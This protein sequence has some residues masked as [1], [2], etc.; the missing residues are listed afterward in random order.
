MKV[1]GSPVPWVFLFISPFLFCALGLPQAAR[2]SLDSWHWLRPQPTSFSLLDVAEGPELLVAVGG[3]GTIQ[4][5]SDGISWI[6]R[7]S[8]VT[9]TLRGIAY[10]QNQFVAAGNGSVL[11]SSNGLSW[12]CRPT[13]T[14]KQLGGIAYGNGMF[15]AFTVDSPYEILR[16]FDA[17]TWIFSPYTNVFSSLNQVRFCNGLFIGTSS[18]GIVTSTNGVDWQEANISPSYTYLTFDAIYAGGAWYAIGD[19]YALRST[20]GQNWSATWLGFVSGYALAYG[21]GTL[22]GVGPEGAVC[23]SNNGTNWTTT[24]TGPA[25]LLGLAF[26]KN[27]FVAVGSSG[28]VLTS[29]NGISWNVVEGN[30][31]NLHRIAKVGERYYAVG[32]SGAII[33]SADSLHWTNLAAVTTSP[34]HDVVGNDG[35]ML[36]VGENGTVVTSTN[37][38]N[39]RRGRVSNGSAYLNSVAFGNGQFV[40]TDGFTMYVSTNGTNWAV[41]SVG[42]LSGITKVAF[43]GGFFVAV[44]GDGRVLTSTDGATWTQR[45][46]GTS[47]D[48]YD[49]I[50]ANGSYL[51]VGDVLAVSPDGIHWTNAPSAFPLRRVAY[52]QNTY[53][54]V[55][56][57]GTVTS[58]PDGTNWFARNSGTFSLEHVVAA[59]GAFTAVG[60]G[61]TVMQASVSGPLTTLS[62]ERNPSGSLELTGSVDIGKP[63][64]LQHSADLDVWHGVFDFVPVQSVWQFID[65]TGSEPRHFYRLIPKP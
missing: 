57:S 50:F 61:G 12:E 37:G 4:S 63:Y 47:A 22:V 51:A 54:A 28:T 6:R 2:A 32:D 10:G 58:S 40:T 53:V 17:R 45:A 9:D 16:S 7:Y 3:Y 26:F 39:W 21:N 62:I 64:T 14:W 49:V 48:L 19:N 52:G 41:Y 65:Y 27:K 13:G 5:S 59:D 43:A 34:L 30:G 42:G 24:T 35:L 38:V 20:N 33:S 8:G 15:V 56:V 29:G 44:G 25:T 36:A 18:Y 46:T 1:G 11:V 23:V 55:T 31:A 60:T